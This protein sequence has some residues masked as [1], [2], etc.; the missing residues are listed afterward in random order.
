M[1]EIEIM[2]I[3][4]ITIM[5]ERTMPHPDTRELGIIYF[6]PIEDNTWP[7]QGYRSSLDYGTRSE[8]I[9][10]LYLLGLRVEGIAPCKVTWESNDDFHLHV[11]GSIGCEVKRLGDGNGDVINSTPDEGNVIRLG[12]GNG[13]SI[14][15]KPGVGWAIREG[16]GEGRRINYSKPNHTL[17]YFPTINPHDPSTYYSLI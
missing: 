15:L 1:P 5:V 4:T 14:R 2:P 3:P 6:E 9:Y 10:N 12:N 11:T 8:R 16:K 13:D 17:S 7:M